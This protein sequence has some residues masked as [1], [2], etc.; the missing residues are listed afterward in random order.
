MSTRSHS[1]EPS[2]DQSPMASDTNCRPRLSP[3]R[4]DR[5]CPDHVGGIHLPALCAAWSSFLPGQDIVSL[6]C[7][8][9]KNFLVHAQRSRT[10]ECRRLSV[11]SKSAF[12]L[13]TSVL[14]YD[15]S[16]EKLQLRVKLR[17]VACVVSCAM[18]VTLT[19]PRP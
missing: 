10:Q 3:D 9:R 16:N 18:A 14:S 7:L 6:H 4:S 15:A 5:P 19:E 11:H 13:S 1:S 12:A 2:S 17:A 8:R